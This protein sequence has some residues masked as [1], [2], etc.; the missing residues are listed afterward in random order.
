MEPTPATPNSMPAKHLLEQQLLRM[1]MDHLPEFVFWK[2]RD[3]VFMGCNQKFTDVAG[4][5]SPES[6]VGLTD[7]DL[8]WKK[9][10]SDFFR[11]C[12]RRV[13]E[14]GMP[15]LGIIEPLLQ[16]DGKQA[17]IETNK[18]PLRDAD[19]TV[20]GILG[21]FQD[22]TARYEAEQALKH[23]NEELEKR[24]ELRTAELQQTL[25]QLQSAQIQIVQ[26]EKMSSLGQLVAGVA[27]EINN[28]INFIYGNLPHIQSYAQQLLDA[29]QHYQQND[30]AIADR[31]VAADLPELAF[32]QQDLPQLLN[33][34]QN[35]TN[36]VREVVLSLRNFSRLDESESKTVD[37]HEGIDSAIIMLQHRCTRTDDRP[38]IQIAK[39]YANLPHIECYPGHLN[40]V[41]FNIL[42]N[43]IDA[44]RLPILQS[45]NPTEPTITIRTESV[46]NQ[47]IRITIGDNGVGIPQALQ[48]RLFDP[49][50][51]T[52]PVG[53]GTGMGLSVSYQ[54]ITGNHKGQLYCQSTEG[55]GS[56]FVIILPT[57]LR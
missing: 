12:D 18:I 17:W 42:N 46:D 27:H 32:I 28:P 37:L 5:V 31:A 13:M 47:Q 8:P 23:L 39:N 57:T 34:I 25:Q 9:E 33:S 15:E 2:D 6:I 20:I 4:L 41:F 53:Q 11:L 45:E 44:L 36:R 55:H 24:V 48:S 51:T 16:A 21:C 3:S 19:G 56:E 50:F 14:S 40:Q 29:V 43:A 49:F 1:V 10:E 26:T 54:I 22:I 52:K 38:A 30:R 7:Y 35:G